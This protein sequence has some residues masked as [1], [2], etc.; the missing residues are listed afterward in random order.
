[1]ILGVESSNGSTIKSFDKKVDPKDAELTV[2][3]LRE[4]ARREGWIEN[5][6]WMNYEV[7]HAMVYMGTLSRREA[8]EEFH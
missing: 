7:F 6:D 4:I 1:M 5:Y 3:L 2:K 8:Q